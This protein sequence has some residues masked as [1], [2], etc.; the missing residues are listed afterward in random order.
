MLLH[1]QFEKLDFYLNTFLDTHYRMNASHS[2]EDRHECF[3][4]SLR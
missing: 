4:F 3:A 1:G 2:A